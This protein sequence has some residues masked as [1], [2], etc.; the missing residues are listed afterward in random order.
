MTQSIWNFFWWSGWSIGTKFPGC[1]QLKDKKNSPS[2]INNHLLFN[3]Q[4]S[5]SSTRE[6]ERK[7]CKGLWTDTERE[8][9]P[10]PDQSL[11]MQTSNWSTDW[12][13]FQNLLIFIYLNSGYQ[14][15]GCH[16]SKLLQHL[17][18]VPN[19]LFSFLQSNLSQ[20]RYE[21]ILFTFW[22]SCVVC[23]VLA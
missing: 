4:T 21:S 16:L 18:R 17:S 19:S 7:I 22:P 12:L 15:G 11:W 14:S 1:W 9:P 8:P 6:R 3:V 2:T 13:L 20:K 23:Y 5:Y 10:Q